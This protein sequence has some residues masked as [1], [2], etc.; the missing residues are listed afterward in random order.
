MGIFSGREAHSRSFAKA[1]SWRVTGTI[2]TFVISLIVTGKLT[3]AGSI[4]LTE[5]FTKIMLYYFHERIWAVIPWGHQ[6]PMKDR[7]WIYVDTNKQVGDK[8]HLK[9]FVSQ[10][11]SNEWFAEHDPE[12]VAF[13]YP[14]TPAP[15]PSMVKRFRF[16]E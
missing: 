8:D 15:R 4:A 9:V 6:S 2:D 14:I 11:A 12:G 7:V 1:V 3:L 5:L 13:E 16:S 10:D